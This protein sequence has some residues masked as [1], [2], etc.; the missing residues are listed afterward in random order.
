MSYWKGTRGVTSMRQTGHPKELEGFFDL[1]SAGRRVL[2][3]EV[4]PVSQMPPLP[5]LE[6]RA[7]GEVGGGGG[8]QQ[9]WKLLPGAC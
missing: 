4:R 5:L 3:P 7:L 2:E 1:S 9:R 8:V 6:S